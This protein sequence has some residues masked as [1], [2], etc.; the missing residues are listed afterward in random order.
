L[1]HDTALHDL[2]GASDE[3][4]LVGTLFIGYP[5]DELASEKKRTPF[6]EK[7]TWL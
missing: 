7:T 5:A 6:A 1:V 3:E 4:Q 2:L